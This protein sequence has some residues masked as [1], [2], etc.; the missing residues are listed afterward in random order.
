MET[1]N[2][3]EHSI[4]QEIQW[5]GAFTG[6]GH[7][8]HHGNS[9]DGA[10]NRSDHSMNPA[11]QWVKTFIGNGSSQKINQWIRSFYGSG[12]SGNHLSAIYPKKKI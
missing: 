6:S 3:S 4:H 8:L 9:L 10:I 2:E 5:I 11:I 7:S 1:F 12:N